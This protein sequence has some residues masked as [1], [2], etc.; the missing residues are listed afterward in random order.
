MEEN[1]L[2]KEKEGRR[3]ATERSFGF[4]GNLCTRD[5]FLLPLLFRRK[6]S[7]LKM[8]HGKFS[9]IVVLARARN[10]VNIVIGRG[11]VHRWIVSRVTSCSTVDKRE[12]KF[13]TLDIKRGKRG[14]G[15]GGGP[16]SNKKARHGHSNGNDERVRNS[17][18]SGVVAASVCP[19]VNQAGLL[20]IKCP[21]NRIRQ[22]FFSSPPPSFFLSPLLSPEQAQAY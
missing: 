12:I 14:G 19:R 8:D 17:I 18:A 21:V 20:T 3:R 13:R 16:L 5:S 1:R 15:G 9:F 4:Q 10:V 11:I 2:R 7:P 22:R 6:I